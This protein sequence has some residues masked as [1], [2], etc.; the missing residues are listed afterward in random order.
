[1]EISNKKRTQKIKRNF[2]LI[3]VFLLLVTLF[4]VWK[5]MNALVI[6]FIA[7]DV[8]IILGVLF[9]NFNYIYYSSAN[10][11]IL[12]RYYSVISLLGKEYKAIEFDKHLLYEVKVK[13]AF[14]FSDLSLAIR[15]SKG[16]AEYPDVSLAGLSKEEIKMI[17]RDL[18]EIL[19]A[20]K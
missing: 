14:L 11:K 4:F 12:I 20:V 16:I 9:I 7:A 10:D 19:Q 5:E 3:V 8:L 15:T 17:E 18:N 13:K 6:T 1:M 2:N